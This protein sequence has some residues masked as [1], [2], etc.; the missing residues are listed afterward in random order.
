MCMCT[1]LSFMLSSAWCTLAQMIM[2]T[3]QQ[4]KMESMTAIWLLPVLPAIVTAG[5]GAAVVQTL[6]RQHALDTL[7][8]LTLNAK[9]L[10][11][12]LLC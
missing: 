12:V 4:L 10:P 1:A 3:E 5:A 6:P 9:E 8:V 7:L 11:T 2:F